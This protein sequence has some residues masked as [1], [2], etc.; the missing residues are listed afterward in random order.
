MPP[1][2][3]PDLQSIVKL[4]SQRQ[5]VVEAVTALY[6][7]LQA[8]VD[9]RRPRCDISGRCCR[10]EEFGHRLYVTTIE[11]AAFCAPLPSGR[12]AGPPPPWDGRGCPFQQNR[13]CGVHPIRPMGCRLFFCDSTSDQW[14]HEQYEAFHRQ[15][16][17]MHDA[18]AVPYRYM[19][20]RAALRALRIAKETVANAGV[21]L[22]INGR[23]C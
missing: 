13:L 15:L 7:R 14:Q 23:Q 20:W 10:F 11:L 22:T 6:G 21:S 9:Q 3:D 12:P 4:A 16:R 8:A 2:E 5:E 19:E 1:V 17:Q 18:F